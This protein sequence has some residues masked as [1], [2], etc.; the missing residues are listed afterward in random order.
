[1]PRN[2]RVTIPSMPRE[3]STNAEKFAVAMLAK[4]LD[5]PDQDASHLGGSDEPDGLLYEDG[6]AFAT[7]E[8]RTVM[9]NFDDSE[10]PNGSGWPEID[11][12]L[13]SHPPMR[14]DKG[15]GTWR[16]H[17]APNRAK[18]EQLLTDDS[19]RDLINE[20]IKGLVQNPLSGPSEKFVHDY[21]SLDGPYGDVSDTTDRC[22]VVVHHSE[23]H[24]FI[25]T[26]ADMVSLFLSEKTGEFAQTFGGRESYFAKWA[27]QADKNNVEEIHVVLIYEGQKK[28]EPGMRFKMFA[29]P[30]Y[31]PEGDID[32]GI[33]PAKRWNFWIVTRNPRTNEFV[34]GFSYRDGTWA[35]LAPTSV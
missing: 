1:M 19:L 20:E 28:W 30:N 16:L 25:N 27:K 6:K 33:A 14:L 5:I 23:P 10:R 21:G 13:N 18:V 24:G 12:V 17:V 2:D 35:A 11:E 22:E 3:Y 7:V 31:V 8:V 15:L 9:N 34:A 29:E 32:L 4:L 26:N